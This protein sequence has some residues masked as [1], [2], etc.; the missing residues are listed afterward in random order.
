METLDIKSVAIIG[1]GAAGAAAAAAFAAEKYF[2]RIRV[3]ERRETP[4]GTWI[5]D[6]D[7]NPLIVPQPGK[8]PPEIDPPLEIPQNLP[9]TTP[10]SSQERYDRTPI[11]AELTSNVPAI[12]MSFSDIPFAYGPFVPHWVPKQ[13]IE[14]Y[15]SAHRTDEFLVLNTTVEDVSKSPGG[16]HRWSLTLRQ[17]DPVAKVDRWWKEEFDALIFANGHYSV[18][19]VWFSVPHVKGLDEYIK[20]FPGRV[21]HSKSFRSAEHFRQKNVLVIGNAASGHDVA[22]ALVKTAKLPVYQSR[23]SPARWDGDRPPAGIEWKP[24]VKEYLST[25]EIVFDDGS[26]LSDIDVVIYCTGYKASFP[27][28]NTRNNGAPLWDYAQDRLVGNYLHTF[29][30]EFPTVG[31]V[32]VPRTL[33]FRSFEYQAIALA[34]VFSKRNAIPLPSKEEQERW[35]RE[36]WER[37]RRERRR[38]HDIPWDNGET[39]EYLRQ[40]FEIA[41]LP[42]IEG[43]GRYPPVLGERTR[44]AIEHVKK[45][46]EPGKD[47]DDDDEREEEEGWTVISPGSYKDSLY[48]I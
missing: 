41:G 40:L 23:R 17:H 10:P 3:F 9:A 6:P 28:W 34:R 33:T 30:R 27:F 15:F 29:L 38:F 31:L 44:W 48:F 25:G 21:L 22:D 46:P 1:A 26:V 32:G 37:V 4:G 42:R 47:K 35:E 8:L 13:Y 7:P 2:D 12:A 14:N 20:I 5:F 45:F 43:A 18:P 19:Y 36:R 39:I 16:R 24:I 11:Y